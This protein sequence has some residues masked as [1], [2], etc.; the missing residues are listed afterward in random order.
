M[1]LNLWECSSLFLRTSFLRYYTFFL[2]SGHD[3][4]FII[5]FTCDIFFLINLHYYFRNFAIG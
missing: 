1:F 2:S 3:N 5:F 4:D